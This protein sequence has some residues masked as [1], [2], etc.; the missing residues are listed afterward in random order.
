MAANHQERNKYWDAWEEFAIAFG[1]DPWL[2]GTQEAKKIVALQAF[3]ERV[4]TGTYGRGKT[5]R[6]PTVQ[7]ALRAIGQK[8]E[9]AGKPN[10]T[11]RAHN[12]YILPLKRQLEGM[13]RSD[14][15]PDHKLA[16][17]VD[18]PDFIYR[19][20]Y[21]SGIHRLEAV[22][23]LSIIAFYYLLRVGEYTYHGPKSNRRTQQ[24]RVLDVTFRHNGNVI[25]NTSS[26]RTL[27]RATE[28]TLFISNQKNGVRGQC[29]HHEAFARA[30][31]P[32]KAL[33]RRVAHIMHYTTNQ[34][35][36]LGTYFDNFGYKRY[37]VSDDMNK[38][39]KEAVVAL[40]LL[41]KGFTPKNVSSHSFRAGGAMACKLNGIDRDT[42]KKLGRWSSDT[43]LMYI[44]EQ[45]SHLTVGVAKKMSTR[46]PFR[47][48]AAV[49]LTN[50]PQS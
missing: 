31:C 47:N 9:L 22:G 7:V 26:L 24:F 43:F 6:T 15:P 46:I 27:L 44:H 19:R 40:G 14:P 25:D 10:P 3:A 8:F 16:V 48:I 38:A 13:R 23:D 28:A 1:I 32:I 39:V 12:Q 11:Y 20:G 37:I 33:A 17:P 2:C 29:V 5:I 42:I 49:R 4:R 41:T 35:T 18:V 50:P 34:H 36:M 45:I 21:T 30:D